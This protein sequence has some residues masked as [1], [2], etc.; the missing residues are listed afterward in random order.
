MSDGMTPSTGRHEPMTKQTFHEDYEEPFAVEAVDLAAVASRD[1]ESVQSVESMKNVMN[2]DATVNSGN[3]REPK[4]RNTSK[5]VGSVASDGAVD[6]SYESRESREKPKLDL[7][8]NALVAFIPDE[9]SFENEENGVSRPILPVLLIIIGVILGVIVV[10]ALI[11]TIMNGNLLRTR[12]TLPP[13]TPP[14]S[15]EQAPLHDVQAQKVSQM[16]W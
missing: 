4:V 10:A 7:K 15:P 6:V 8:Q 14:A 9:R 5:A 12:P 11:S 1:T 3:I 16:E 13:Q 2:P